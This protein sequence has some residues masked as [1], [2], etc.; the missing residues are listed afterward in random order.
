MWRYR[1]HVIALR[2]TIH[3]SVNQYP[4]NEQRLLYDIEGANVI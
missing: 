4:V 3:A 2:M 1:A